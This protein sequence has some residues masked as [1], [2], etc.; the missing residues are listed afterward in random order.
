MMVVK[1]VGIR[2]CSSAWMISGKGDEATS[3]IAICTDSHERMRMLTKRS[4]P[5]SVIVKFHMI[6]WNVERGLPGI[7]NRMVMAIN[8]NGNAISDRLSVNPTPRLES[9]LASSRNNQEK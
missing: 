2:K 6:K 4:N 1:M 7:E 3:R 9:R 5:V 8:A